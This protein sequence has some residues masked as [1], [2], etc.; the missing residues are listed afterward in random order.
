MSVTISELY[1]LKKEK[2]NNQKETYNKI[3]EL[4]VKKIK[5][6]ARSGGYNT[7][8][9]IPGILIGLPLYDTNECIKYIMKMLKKGG[10]FVQRLPENN[11]NII[12]IS[13]DPNDVS[14]IKS[15]KKVLNYN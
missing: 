14:S 3:A 9:A 12:Y 10:F 2:E 11:D 4:C 13:W 15:S 6:V 8:Y 1:N 5:R 7:F